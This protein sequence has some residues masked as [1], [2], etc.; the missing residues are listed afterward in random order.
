MAA[1]WTTEDCVHFTHQM[2]ENH[3]DGFVFSTPPATARCS[4]ELHGLRAL[5]SE[6]RQEACTSFFVYVCL[7]SKGHVNVSQEFS[8]QTSVWWEYWTNL[9]F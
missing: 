2:V 8:C 4:R 1:S 5:Q 6:S 3:C 7:C 9:S